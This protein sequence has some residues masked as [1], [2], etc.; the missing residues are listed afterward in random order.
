[1]P[2]VELSDED[3]SFLT[4]LAA[5]EEARC[6]RK[7][8]NPVFTGEVRDALTEQA[9]R[10]L[11]VAGRI[12]RHR[13]G[14]YVFLPGGWEACERGNTLLSREDG[15]V[16]AWLGLPGG[17]RLEVTHEPHNYPSLCLRLLSAEA[18]SDSALAAHISH[19]LG[20]WR[21]LKCNLPGMTVGPDGLVAGPDG[22][23]DQEKDDGAGDA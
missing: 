11:A 20:G 16:V 5:G 10:C 13:S 14:G 22:P 8:D 21:A 3:I 23:S 1:M 12:G 4:G 9:D 19:K 2:L 17:R 15:G 7:A 6:R 18:G